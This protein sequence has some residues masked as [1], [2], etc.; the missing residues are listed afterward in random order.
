MSR[1]E[2]VPL[3]QMYLKCVYIALDFISYLFV[4]V[5]VHCI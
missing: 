5:A 4:Y 2:H 1:I 3:T